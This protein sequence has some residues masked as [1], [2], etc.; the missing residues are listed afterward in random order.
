MLLIIIAFL[1]RYY[2][3]LPYD[4]TTVAS[5][6]FVLSNTLIPVCSI[7]TSL[8]S[9]VLDVLKRLLALG[10]T[11]T[12][13]LRLLLLSSTASLRRI[14][15]INNIDFHNIPI[16]FQIIVPTMV[17]STFLARWLVLLFERRLAFLSVGILLF[18]HL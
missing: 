16:L 10:L 12:V 5:P 18:L 8:F 6:L 3:I 17:S 11:T 2:I 1:A 9:T 7:T 14:P 4:L 15:L 13:R